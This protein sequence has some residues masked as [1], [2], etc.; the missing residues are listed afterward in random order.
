MHNQSCYLQQE[1]KWKNESSLSVAC[2]V[3]WWHESC[4]CIERVQ[5]FRLST[6][7]HVADAILRHYT[8]IADCSLT[9]HSWYMNNHNIY[10][11]SFICSRL[12]DLTA[13]T[14]L[15]N[16]TRILFAAIKTNCGREYKACPLRYDHRSNTWHDCTWPS[17]PTNWSYQY[18]LHESKIGVMIT[19]YWGDVQVCFVQWN[20]CR[21]FKREDCCLVPLFFTWRSALALCNLKYP[22][23]CVSS[24]AASYNNKKG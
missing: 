16:S 24:L 6:T 5:I 13:S 22:N 3:E 9:S 19:Y 21:C 20:L 14:I 11:I 10:I 17:E 7:K 1:S 8:S 15:K 23:H 2:L 4:S 18:V 12:S